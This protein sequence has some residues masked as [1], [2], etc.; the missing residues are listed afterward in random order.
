MGGREQRQFGVAREMGV[1]RHGVANWEKGLKE[2][3]AA[4][5]PTVISFLGYELSPAPKT[6]VMV[7]ASFAGQVCPALADRGL[8]LSAIGFK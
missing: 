2:P 6:Q 4:Q 3:V 1:D 8:Q 5:Y 7:V